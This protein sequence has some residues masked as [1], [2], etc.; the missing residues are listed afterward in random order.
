MTAEEIPLSVALA[1]AEY[2]SSLPVELSSD[3]VLRL[4]KLITTYGLQKQNEVLDFA[5]DNFSISHQS[6][7]RN[8]DGR[9]YNLEEL[10]NLKNKL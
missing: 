5:R 10:I 6:F 3:N 4:C 7:V 8:Y 1:V 9:E 2:V